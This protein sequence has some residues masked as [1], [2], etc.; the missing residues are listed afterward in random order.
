MRKLLSLGLLFVFALNGLAQSNVDTTTYILEEV[1]V[2]TDFFDV[3]KKEF[4][5]SVSTITPKVLE[6]SEGLYLQPVLN[7]IPG[8]YMQSGALNTNRITIR[9]IGSRTPFGTDKIK[10]YLDE[11]PLSTGE[12]E[13]TVEDIDF[14]TLQ[15]LEVYRG[16]SS[17]AYGAGL[18]G[19]IHLLTKRPQN[20]ANLSAGYTIGSYGLK[21]FDLSGQVGGD[22]QS[23]GV[24]YQDVS[25]DGYRDN[26]EYDRQSLTLLSKTALGSKSTITAYFN[27][28][29]L[30][31]QI[32]SSLNREMYDSIPSAAEPRWGNAQGFEDN[33]RLRFGLSLYTDWDDRT[34]SS[35]A[36]FVNLGESDEV[37]PIFLGNTAGEFKNFGFRGR[38]KRKFGS[39]EK[40][41]VVLGGEVFFEDF[42]YQEFVNQAGQN[43]PKTLDFD[44]NRNYGN[45]FL[46]GEF[47]PSDSWVLSVG[48]NMNFST[49]K[50]QD[51]FP[52]DST[53]YSREY[54]FGSI[55]SPKLSITKAINDDI[56]VYGVYSHGFSLP[57]F[58][59]TIYPQEGD[60]RINDQIKE[61][62]GNN[63]EI[64]VKAHVYDRR[65]YFEVAAYHMD[66]DD[67]LV[68]ETV[69]TGTFAVNAGSADFNGVEIFI[70]HE[71]WKTSFVN[72]RQTFS[73]TWMDYKFSDFTHRGEDYS[74]N[75]VTGIPD[76]TLD[77][78]LNADFELG[79]Y[80]SINWQGTGEIFLRD[81]NE[82]K[83]ESY[84]LLNLKAGYMKEFGKIGLDVSGGINNATD[85]KYASMI[86]PN[87]F[88]GRY[89]YPGLPVNY[90]TSVRL[91]YN[92]K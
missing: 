20:G 72:L 3:K 8:V 38:V 79:L 40:L 90:F 63:Y 1:S 15:G 60:S 84:G 71:L 6:K 59:Q 22:N 23:L 66:V 75:V 10:A 91:T 51:M 26:N 58:E 70:Q 39:E 13:T 61:E 21:K 48:G 43:G 19:A 7:T 5:G 29:N 31:A 89:Y 9:G 25:S 76:Y 14:R 88:G 54:S 64:G 47:R 82:E 27:S 56:S 17:T 68:T 73:Y 67:L 62:V 33:Q 36:G 28:T 44:Q 49:Y 45:V 50:N 35:L 87:A 86:Q 30:V 24:F 85:A 77:Y 65:I 81:D 41:N 4:G 11:I 69:E 80:A 34:E 42:R 32:P 16:P 57:T 83:S 74:G 52:S 2:Q 55:F 46:I 12:G 53:D 78:S 18:G 92:F 37:R